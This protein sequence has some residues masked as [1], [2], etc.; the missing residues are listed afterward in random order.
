VSAVGAARLDDDDE[1]ARVAK[2]I[3]ELEGSFIV[4]RM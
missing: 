4:K 3:E 1:I 2:T